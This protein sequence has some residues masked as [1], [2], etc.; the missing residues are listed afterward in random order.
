MT[1]NQRLS[2]KWYVEKMGRFI[3]LIETFVIIAHVKI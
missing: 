2:H 3:V 1:L